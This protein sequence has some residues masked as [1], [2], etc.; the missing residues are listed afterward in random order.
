MR[1][2]LIIIFGY[3]L[4]IYSLYADFP[5]SKEAKI[6]ENTS[7]IE[8]LIEST[9]IYKS[10]LENKRFSKKAEKDIKQ[11]GM[12]L[13]SLDAKRAAVY[14]VLF[15]G[16]DALLKF[17][18]EEK[19]KKYQESYFGIES[20]NRFVMYEEDNVRKRVVIDNGTA[21]RVIKRFK[22]NREKL[23]ESLERDGIIQKRKEVMAEIGKP[24]IMVIPQTVKGKSPLE[25]LESDKK[26]KHSAAAIESYLTSKQYD[27]V[28]PEQQ[29]LINSLNQMQ[30]MSG[31]DM[32][33]QIALALGSDIYISFD[34]QME[35]AGYGTKKYAMSAK[36]YET[37]TARL[38]GTETGYSRARTGEESISIEEA[39]NDS[40]DKVLARVNRYWEDDMQ[41]GIQYKIIAKISEDFYEDEIEDVQFGFDDVLNEISKTYKSNVI[42]DGSMDYIIWVDGKE[43]ENNLKVYREIKSIFKKQGLD[44]YV[45]RV[46]IN[47]KV[48]VLDIKRR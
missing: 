20:I 12:R 16:T 43:Y 10:K 7:H 1:K 18:D 42:T 21:L 15:N 41:N 28:V 44:A 33:Y 38:L 46:S 32:A 6:I 48:L 27:V 25:K 4:I 9:G 2:N 8:I 35:D 22:I 23:I 40:I 45:K 31:G 13:A 26:S 29:G 17:E 37:T 36:A 5:T 47:R 19:I 30:D 39:V 11:N 24:F 34:G 3:F 14:Y